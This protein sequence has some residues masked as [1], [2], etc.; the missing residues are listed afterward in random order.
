M[1]LTDRQTSLFFKGDATKRRKENEEKKKR[2]EEQK[3]LK[4]KTIDI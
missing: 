2:K 1:V 3:D 4:G